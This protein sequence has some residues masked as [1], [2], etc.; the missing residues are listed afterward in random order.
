MKCDCGKHKHRSA[1]MCAVCME[2]LES[3]P[4]EISAEVLERIKNLEHIRDWIHSHPNKVDAEVRPAAIDWL[5]GEI[6]TLKK[7]NGVG[8]AKLSL[9]SIFTFW[10][11]DSAAIIS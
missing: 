3:E 10:E 2:R 1:A 11:N 6:A 5:N 9:K 4:A 8:A 7:P